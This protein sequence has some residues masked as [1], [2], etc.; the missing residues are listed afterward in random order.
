MLPEQ[1][2]K[3]PGELSSTIRVL[4]SHAN[5]LGLKHADQRTVEKEK[6]PRHFT[7]RYLVTRHLN[8]CSA[9]WCEEDRQAI[10]RSRKNCGG[11]PG[12]WSRHFLTCVDFGDVGPDLLEDTSTMVRAVDSTPVTEPHLVCPLFATDS[13]SQQPPGSNRGLAFSAPYAPQ[14]TTDDS[15]QQ[16]SD[17]VH[18]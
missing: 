7:A 18:P 17:T 12:G 6:P 16:R 11:E 2:T 10:L 8:K 1:V 3:I 13:S 4:A 14:N 15:L 9:V 5:L